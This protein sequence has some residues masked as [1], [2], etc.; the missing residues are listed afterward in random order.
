M[1][2]RELFQCRPTWKFEFATNPRATTPCHRRNTFALLVLHNI[3][4]H[5]SHRPHPRGSARIGCR[6]PGFGGKGFARWYVDPFG[7][8]A[9]TLR[10]RPDSRFQTLGTYHAAGAVPVHLPI[11]SCCSFL[12]ADTCI[13]SARSAT[14]P[15]FVQYLPSMHPGKV[16]TISYCCVWQSSMIPTPV[17]VAR[18]FLSY[19]SYRC[20]VTEKQA[21]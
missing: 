5:W 18:L 14:N 2:E 12:M 4:C 8:L 17:C 20:C 16:R 11:S 15:I 7:G 9:R 3:T 10:V 19:L 1:Q 21:L 6:V 13:P